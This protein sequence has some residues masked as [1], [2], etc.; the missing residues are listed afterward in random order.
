MQQH[1]PA[2]P[3]GLW[4]VRLRQGFDRQQFTS[5]ASGQL[6]AVARDEIALLFERAL[7]PRAPSALRPAA[8]RAP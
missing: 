7:A 2:L 4:V 6:Q 5:P 1:A 3:P 8:S